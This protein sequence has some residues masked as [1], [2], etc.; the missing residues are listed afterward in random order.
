M[1]VFAT[2]PFKFITE[3]DN[4]VTKYTE[5][6]NEILDYLCIIETRCTYKAVAEVL[7]INPRS[8]GRYLGQK[9]PEASWVVNGKTEEPTGYAGNQKHPRLHKHNVIIRSGEELQK[10]LHTYRRDLGEV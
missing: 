5:Y 6:I 4:R 3:I 9:R 2:P 8:V 10:G 1:V 7:G